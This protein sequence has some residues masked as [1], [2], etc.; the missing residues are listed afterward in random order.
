MSMVPPAPI[1]P[2]PVNP[3]DEEIIRI[4]V[5]LSKHPTTVPNLDGELAEKE[6]HWYHKRAGELARANLEALVTNSDKALD[7]EKLS[8]WFDPELSEEYAKLKKVSL[9]GDKLATDECAKLIKAVLLASRQQA[10]GELLTTSEYAEGINEQI[11]KD[12]EKKRVEAEKLEGK[13]Q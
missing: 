9:A 8:E 4:G 6:T 11:E 2:V 3:V 5:N 10:R 7:N 13:I 1:E 12:M